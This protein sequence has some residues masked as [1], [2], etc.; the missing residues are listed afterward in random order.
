MYLLECDRYIHWHVMNDEVVCNI[1]WTQPDVVKLLNAFNIVF[2]MDNTYKTNRYRLPLLEIIGVTCTVL[3][4]SAS[5]AYMKVEREKKIRW[6]LERFR[7][8]FRK[9]DE[10]KSDCNKQRP[11]FDEC[12]KNCV[13]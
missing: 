8:L 2:Y 6:A 9:H 13:S 11:N 3:T 1:F 7:G 5:F 12:S 4:F 10:S